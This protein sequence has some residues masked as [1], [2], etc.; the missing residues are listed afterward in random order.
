VS[1]VRSFCCGIKIE[2]YR[3]PF[4]EY[5]WCRICENQV[6]ADGSDGRATRKEDRTFYPSDDIHSAIY[7]IK[8]AAL[9]LGASKGVR[10][11]SEK[12][13]IEWCREAFFW[14]AKWREVVS[15]ISGDSV[16][17]HQAEE[18]YP[19]PSKFESPPPSAP[20]K[21]EK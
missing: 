12:Q 5:H 7:L 15:C 10:D 4:G 19:M 14:G 16:I 17:R 20:G 1:D 13:R 6:K 11:W 18:M 9:F 3:S 2:S 21:E 8:K